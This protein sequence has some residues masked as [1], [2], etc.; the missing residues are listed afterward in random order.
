LTIFQGTKERARS[1]LRESPAYHPEPWTNQPDSVRV[2]YDSDGVTD[3]PC[4]PGQRQRIAYVEIA[5]F[6]YKDPGRKKSYVH[7]KL[8]PLPIKARAAA[9]AAR[10]IVS[11]AYNARYDSADE[12]EKQVES[13][14][15]VGPEEVVIAGDKFLTKDDEP[16]STTAPQMSIGDAKITLRFRQ[17]GQQSLCHQCLETSRSPKMSCCNTEVE[18]SLRFCE[19]C[20]K[21]RYVGGIP[22]PMS[23]R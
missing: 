1:K 23:E 22:S 15:E 14:D 3:E 12:G 19:G 9:L 8:P 20:V 4:K 5:P 17:D 16:V 13:G 10:E 21:E 18:C 11:G 6:L 2:N 7:Q